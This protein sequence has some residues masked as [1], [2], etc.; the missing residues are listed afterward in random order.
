MVRPKSPGL[1][2]RESQIMA[3][4]WELGEAN[5]DDIRARLPQDLHDSTVR[6]VLRTME[7]KKL[8]KHRVERRVYI[9]RPI[10]RQTAARRKA[11]T[12]LV[13]QLFDG[14]ART[15]ILQLLE[16]EKITAEELK[17]IADSTK[18]PAPKNKRG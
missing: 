17:E 1:T 8:V 5:A 10:V 15:L 2:A 3:V 16:D 18:S 14:S 9:Y 13:K 4:L 12:G 7:T 11:V 6:S